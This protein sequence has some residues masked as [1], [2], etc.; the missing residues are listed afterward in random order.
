[1]RHKIAYPL[2]DDLRAFF[3]QEL[4]AAVGAEKLDLF[5]AQLLGVAIKF[6]FA[7]RTGHPKYFGHDSSGSTA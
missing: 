1:L 2:F 7:L 4:V 5:V 6:A 3:I